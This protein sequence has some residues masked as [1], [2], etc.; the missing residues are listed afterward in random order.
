MNKPL[1]IAHRGASAYAP[2]NTLSS[3]K[4]AVQLGAD[5]IELD[6]QLSRDGH[7]VVIHDTYVNRTSNGNGRVR[8]L[9][10]KQLKAL[11]FGSWFSDEF[12]N[13]PICTLEEVF[14][15]LKGWN[16][17]INVEIKREWLQFTSIE[18]KVAELI[19]KFDRQTKTIVS[20]FS[21]FSL[22]KI[23]RINKDI[24]TGILYSSSAKK[25]ITH[26]MR[27]K[28]DAIH[29]WYQNVTKDMKK[30]AS[31]NNIKI[32]T[33]TVDN[34]DAIKKLADIGVDG[35]ITNVPDIALKVVKKV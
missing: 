32:N 17:L 12:K 10:L 16:G 9:T 7:V 24:K 19:K 35:I 13:E 25:P 28:A 11:D 23:K 4:K 5:G 18:K 31:Q 20:S 2:E 22:A 6:V 3:F 26:A 34:P 8:S 21:V 27:I 30:D 1:I 29:P 15:Y 14:S 33:Y